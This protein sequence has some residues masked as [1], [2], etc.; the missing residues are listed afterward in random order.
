MAT[1]NAFVR[2]N[3][4][5]IMSLETF[6]N[7]VIQFGHRV[8]DTSELQISGT[9]YS[10]EVNGD[11]SLPTICM[12]ADNAHKYIRAVD[13][14]QYSATLALA[15]GTLRR[16]SIKHKTPVYLDIRDP[17]NDDI[18]VSIFTNSVKNPSIDVSNI[19]LYQDNYRAMW[20][21]TL[22]AVP[23]E[24]VDGNAGTKVLASQTVELEL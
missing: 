16:L 10:S 12:E 6:A 2:I 23:S 4:T 3:N 22:G 11:I 15:T 17:G 13:T 5:H 14:S 8:V 21:V 19:S 9:V 24:G 18:V 7:S 1:D 20:S